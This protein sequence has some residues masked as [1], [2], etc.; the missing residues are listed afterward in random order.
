MTCPCDEVPADEAAWGAVSTLLTQAAEL[1]AED[2][3]PTTP[4]V[5]EAGAFGECRAWHLP[6]HTAHWVLRQAR[7]QIACTLAS[8]IPLRDPDDPLINTVLDVLAHHPTDIQAR[9]LQA[10][11]THLPHHPAACEA[12]PATAST[13]DTTRS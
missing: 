5:L 3:V 7:Y 8:A 12:R 2:D 9:V 4:Q 11:T 6:D 13:P 1:A 10:A